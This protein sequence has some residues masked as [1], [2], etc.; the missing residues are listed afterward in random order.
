MKKDPALFDAGEGKPIT[1][2]FLIAEKSLNDIILFV[3]RARPW[4]HL[5]KEAPRSPERGA[6]L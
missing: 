6:S 5:R 3:D 1:D 2:T 4:P